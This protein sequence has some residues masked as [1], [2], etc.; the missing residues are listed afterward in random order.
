MLYSVLSTLLM[1]LARRDVF[2]GAKGSDR[3]RE[4][5]RNGFASGGDRGG[6]MFTEA[7]PRFG[8]LAEGLTFG[9][10]TGAN[11]FPFGTG[12]FGFGTG[13]GGLGAPFGEMGGVGLLPGVGF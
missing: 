2:E 10:F 1:R 12:E 4:G 3:R 8:W 5:M 7:I 13:G 6:D 11:G 9:C